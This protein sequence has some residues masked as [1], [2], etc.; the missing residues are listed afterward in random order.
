MYWFAPILRGPGTPRSYVVLSLFC[1][2]W[3]IP[4]L[5]YS[6]VVL[7]PMGL[8]FS[9]AHQ[10]P[11]PVTH[12]SSCL[13]TVSTTVV[14]VQH[15]QRTEQGDGQSGATVTDYTSVAYSNPVVTVT[16]VAHNWDIK[17]G[18]RVD[19]RMWEGKVI[20]I[21]NSS[22]HFDT[23]YD[24]GLA[25]LVVLLVAVAGTALGGFLVAK[26]IRIWVRIR[27]G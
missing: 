9:T 12:A 2:I 24:P 5:T 8:A 1:L 15:Y 23:G 17:K 13:Y 14:A 6:L 7:A 20:T 26:G 16:T 21:S 27:V 25:T 3:S 4:L 18:E 22:S 10:C 11:P 19:V